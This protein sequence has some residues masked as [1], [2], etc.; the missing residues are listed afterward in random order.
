MRKTIAKM[1]GLSG[2]RREK[3]RGERQ[4]ERTGQLHRTMEEKQQ[5]LYSDLISDQMM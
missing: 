2:D 5:W 1:A 3:G 4:V